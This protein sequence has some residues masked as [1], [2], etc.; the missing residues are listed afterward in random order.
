MKFL[1]LRFSSIGDIVLTTPVIRCLRKKYPNAEIHFATKQAFASLLTSNPYLDKVHLLGD[2]DSKLHKQLKQ[3][4]F[5][6]VIDLHHNQ[7]TALIKVQLG[8][9]SL[10]FN[11][12]N[13]EK[14]AMVHFKWN[15]LP[16][17][18]IVDRYLATC[19]NLGVVNDGL[20][21]DYFIPSAEEIDLQ[22]L[23]TD[24]RNGYIAW[25][26]GA[27]HFTKRFPPAK[28][29]AAISNLHTPVVLLGGK[30]DSDNASIIFKELR[31]TPALLWN[32][33][34]Q[35]NI[36]QSASL[37]RQSQ[38]VVSNDTGLMHIAAALH[39]PIVSLWGNTIPA[40]GMTPYYGS[41]KVSGAIIES[42][43]LTCRPCSKIG[44]SDCP[45]G[46]FDCMMK[47][48]ENYIAYTINSL[49]AS[50]A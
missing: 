46:H 11:K 35:F 19:A 31:A 47:L 3:E 45:K 10:S 1:I 22:S 17:L 40:F 24:F 27:Q 33:V 28:V 39:K 13:L 14:W 2:S 20:G 49:L 41:Q 23:P 26:I 8:T 48:D 18:H 43:N 29:A 5:D 30:E 25:A 50:K 4:Q 34:G 15:Y 38:L 6:Y 44:Q 32:A 42:K 16:T 37:I 7:R 36:H 9:E 21:L 12:L